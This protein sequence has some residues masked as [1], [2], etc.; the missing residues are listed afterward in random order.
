MLRRL[1][2]AEKKESIKGEEKDLLDTQQAIQGQIMSRSKTVLLK[3]AD[4]K[5][6][7]NELRYV[8]LLCSHFYVVLA[9][10]A[11]DV[12]GRRNLLGSVCNF[13]Y[14]YL[15]LL[16]FYQTSFITFIIYK[17]LRM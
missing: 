16:V 12:L 6:Q 3:S 17:Y 11:T 2:D 13:V 8:H 15:Y 14:L 1:S 7:E 9:A 5:D 10:R 4:H